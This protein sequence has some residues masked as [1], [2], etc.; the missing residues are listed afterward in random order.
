MS[1]LMV[2]ST[3]ES[4]ITKPSEFAIAFLA[5]AEKSG[6]SRPFVDSVSKPSKDSFFIKSDDRGSVNGV[7]KKDETIFV[8]AKMGSSA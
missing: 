8:L 2:L 7:L 1:F 6:V 3:S 4:E 5:R